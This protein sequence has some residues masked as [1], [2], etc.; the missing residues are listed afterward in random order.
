MGRDYQRRVIFLQEKKNWFSQLMVQIVRQLEFGWIWGGGWIFSIRQSGRLLLEPG[1][2][3]TGPKANKQSSWRWRRSTQRQWRWWWWQPCFFI[4]EKTHI[5]FVG[6][7]AAA[8]LV[9]SE[10][11]I[12][13]KR[14][15][16]KGKEVSWNAKP[17]VVLLLDDTRWWRC[18]IQPWLI[19]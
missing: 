12:S 3:T 17:R 2:K 19:V 14:N 4:Q 18:K 7:T 11:T 16:R 15:K 13:K 9:L 8:S 6:A 5:A 10:Q 1:S